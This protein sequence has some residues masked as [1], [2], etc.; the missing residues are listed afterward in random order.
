[1]PK[2][3]ISKA[4]AVLGVK[5]KSKTPLAKSAERAIV[6]NVMLGEKLKAKTATETRTINQITGRKAASTSSK[7]TSNLM[8]DLV[9]LH[10]LNSKLLEIGIGMTEKQFIQDFSIVQL[11]AYAIAKSKGWWAS[12]RRDGEL[13]ALVHSELSEGL[14]GLRHGNPPSEHIA[15]FSA[16]EE[17]YADVIIRIMDHAQHNGWRVGEAIVAK[18]RFNEGRA[19]KH[20][21]KKF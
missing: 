21:G 14:E 2:R 1:M 4:E 8:P 18:L 13:I 12:P 10:Q 19:H 20:G 6:S 3:S 11:K 17:E 9:R 7:A 5:L 15:P 16:I